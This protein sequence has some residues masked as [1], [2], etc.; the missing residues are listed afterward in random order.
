MT[1]RLGVPRSQRSTLPVDS[2]TIASL[3]AFTRGISTLTAPSMVTPKAASLRATCAARGLATSVLV[4]M[5]PTLTQVPPK[6]LRSRIA[7]LR[8]RLA[9]RTASDGPAWPVPMTIA[10]NRSSLI[11]APST[12]RASRLVCLGKNYFLSS[13]FDQFRSAASVLFDVLARI[14]AHVV[15]VADTRCTY[16]GRDRSRPPGGERS[17]PV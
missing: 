11:D 4:G 1:V 10:S 3:R 7:V 2:A 17:G 6:R 13:F 9:R 14:Q 5:Q 12:D 8:P 15:V 16:S